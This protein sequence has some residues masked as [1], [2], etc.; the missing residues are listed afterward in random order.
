VRRQ[1]AEEDKKKPGRENFSSRLRTDP[2]RLHNIPTN[3]GHLCTPTTCPQSEGKGGAQEYPGSPSSPLPRSTMSNDPGTKDTS[4]KAAS[5]DGLRPVSLEGPGSKAAQ[6][7]A[8]VDQGSAPF[9]RPSLVC[10]DVLAPAAPVWACASA[11]PTSVP[12]ALS[13]P[14]KAPSKLLPT[15]FGLERKALRELVGTPIDKSLESPM[16]ASYSKT[17]KLQAQV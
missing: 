11:S 4:S 5:Q 10:D 15:L 16:Y 3:H 14:Q 6:E 17:I 13:L 7:G 12:L 8:P 2:G 1:E 9:I